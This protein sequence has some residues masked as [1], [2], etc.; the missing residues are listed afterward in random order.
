MAIEATA[1]NID[2]DELNEVETP[3][4]ETETPVVEEE[5]EQNTQTSNESDDDDDE[6]G[7]PSRKDPTE[8]MTPEQ[9]VE[10]WQKRAKHFESD[11]KKERTKRQNYQKGSS[12]ATSFTGKN[13]FADTNES[14]EANTKAIDEITD[15]KEFRQR[16]IN[17]TKNEIRKEMTEKQLHQRMLDSEAE[18]REEFDGSDGRPPFDEVMDKYVKKFFQETAAEDKERAKGIFNLM[19]MMPNPARAAYTLGMMLA[20]QEA[21]GSV[22]KKVAS[23]ARADLV[24]KVDEAAQKAA[25]L[26]SRADTGKTSKKKSA[27]EIEAMSFDDFEREIEAAKNQ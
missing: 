16:L 11:Y 22:D 17:D 21:P 9:K 18:A 12:L 27:A 23:K 4:I 8:G 26:K 14:T 5:V 10:F 19:K 13:S 6:Q 1:Q 3:E 7:A 25:T 2:N 24:K 15:P 20:D